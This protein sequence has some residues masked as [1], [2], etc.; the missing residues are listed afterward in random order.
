[1]FKSISVKQL[2]LNA[3]DGE[4][5]MYQGWLFCFYTLSSIYGLWLMYGKPYC[6]FPL[7][8][9]QKMHQLIN[10]PQIDTQADF[11]YYYSYSIGFFAAELIAIFVEARRSDFREYLIHHSVTL[12]LLIFSFISFEH[13]PGGYVILL[14]DMSDIFLCASKMS[15]YARTRPSVTN[16]FFGLFVSSF[17][18]LRLYCLPHQTTMFLTL[19]PTIQYATINFWIMIF[20]LQVLQCLHIFWGVLIV[21]MIVKLATGGHGDL[22]SD[23]EGEGGAKKQKKPK[24][25][26]RSKLEASGK[27]SN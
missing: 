27:K 19:L 2:G 14:H 17:I 21:R 12:Y 8:P 6:S 23:D 26:A 10:H 25:G 18:F 5:F 1:M 20:F 11:I 3:K 15:H 22:R 7:G 4:K 16:V 13:V 9:S 24:A